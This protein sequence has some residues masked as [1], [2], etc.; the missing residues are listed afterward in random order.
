MYISYIQYYRIYIYIT[1]IYIVSHV[2]SCISPYPALKQLVSILLW[3]L[4]GLQGT[5]KEEQRPGS[6]GRPSA[7][8]DLHSF[9]G[10]RGAWQLHGFWSFCWDIFFFTRNYW[11]LTTVFFCWCNKSSWSKRSRFN[12]SPRHKRDLPN[13]PS[14]WWSRLGPKGLFWIDL[15]IDLRSM[16]IINSNDTLSKR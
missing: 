7:A 8:I 13:Y 10:K 4:G 12:T 9:L 1:C 2:I 15:K 11:I 14:F 6:A 5:T 16:M 3:F